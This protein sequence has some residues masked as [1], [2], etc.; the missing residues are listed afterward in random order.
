LPRYQ[1]FPLFGLLVHLGK[2]DQ[3]ET[4]DIV[5]RNF[6]R[7]ARN[8]KSRLVFSETFAKPFE[9]IIAQIKHAAQTDFQVPRFF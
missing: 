7:T 2:G 4:L 1:K 8:I 5:T 6:A 3:G 9:I